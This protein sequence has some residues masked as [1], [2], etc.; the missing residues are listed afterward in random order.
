MMGEVRGI[1]KED[2]REPLSI[3]S[4]LILPMRALNYVVRQSSVRWLKGRSGEGNVTLRL[5]CV[6]QRFVAV[7]Y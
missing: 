7:P 5:R 6:M 1:Q 2:D 3:Q 4:P